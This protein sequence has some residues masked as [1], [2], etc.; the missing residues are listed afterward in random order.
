[1][2]YNLRSRVLPVPSIHRVY[3]DSL[4][5]YQLVKILND[6]DNLIIIKL[7]ERSHSFAGFS[8]YV[9]RKFIEKY[10]DKKIPVLHV[11]EII[12]RNTTKYNLIN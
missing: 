10:S 2:N 1:M 4:F 11:N 7:R 9:S 6:F 5:I 12:V 3:A 8:T